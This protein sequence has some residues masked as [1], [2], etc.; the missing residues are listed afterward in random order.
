MY[1]EGK[2]ALGMCVS[3]LILL[4]KVFEGFVVVVYVFIRVG[5]IFSP[6]EIVLL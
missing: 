3:W 6:N 1:G 2:R 5:K 4:E